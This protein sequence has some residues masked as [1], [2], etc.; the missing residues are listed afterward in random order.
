[1]DMN[2]KKLI[3]IGGSLLGVLVVIII[4]VFLISALKPKFYTYEQ[5]EEKI[6]IATEEYYKANPHM[7]PT[8]DGKHDLSYSTLVNAELIKPLEEMLQN[9][10]N[11]SVNI[12]VNKN[13]ED[14]NYVPYLN[15]PG[16]YE[17]KELYKTIIE[18]NPVVTTGDGLYQINN[19]Y[20][21]KGENVNNYLVL[22]S[23]EDLEDTQY[24]RVIQINSD[25]TIKIVQNT[26]YFKERYVWDDRYNAERQSNY[27]YNDFNVSR[28]K[29]TLNSL[30]NSEEIVLNDTKSKLV[31]K[32]LCIGKRKENEKNIT[33]SIEC[34]VYSENELLFGLLNVSEIT[35]ASIDPKCNSVTSMSC[36][37][38]NYLSN[39]FTSSSWTLTGS[40]D[41]SYKVY[42]YSNSGSSLSNANSTKRL[43]LTTNISD[44]VFYKSGTGTIDDPYILR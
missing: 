1:M 28:I 35:K 30:S 18:H 3:I 21:F 31:P 43:L 37:N 20:I 11:C 36:T 14:F 15:C 26:F 9:P 32:K 27:G 23:S 38:Y 2:K 10:S 4:I 5:L 6:L 12:I 24:W 19:E 22:E 25:N 42:S 7:L 8:S 44:S 40:S 13:G 41:K 16:E 17:T 33:G 39:L 29:E 34:S